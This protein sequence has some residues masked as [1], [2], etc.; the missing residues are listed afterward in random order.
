M[1]VQSKKT[2]FVTLTA[3]HT[4]DD[5]GSG[6]VGFLVSPIAFKALIE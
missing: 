3:T 5:S 4:A 2:G 6:S 1:C